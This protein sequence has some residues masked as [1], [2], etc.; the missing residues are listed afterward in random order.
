MT[1]TGGQLLLV[2]ANTEEGLP[3]RGTFIRLWVETPGRFSGYAR[4]G[5]SGCICETGIK[6]A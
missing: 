6:I 5:D 1:A 3:K 4:P 2:M